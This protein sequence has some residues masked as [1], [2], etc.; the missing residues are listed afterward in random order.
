M[1]SGSS[2]AHE[3]GNDVALAAKA[4]VIIGSIETVGSYM[5]HS[6]AEQLLLFGNTL[7]QTDTLMESRERKVLNKVNAVN[8]YH[9]YFGSKFYRL[10]FLASDD[11]TDIGLV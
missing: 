3:A 6:V 5:R 4:T 7:R 9:I 1:L 8:L 2:L 10:G 11:G